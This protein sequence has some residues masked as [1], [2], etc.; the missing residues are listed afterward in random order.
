[1]GFYAP[2]QLVADAK[3]HGVAVR[4]ADVN[5]SDWDCT[6]EPSKCAGRM[7]VRLGLWMVRSLRED[8]AER[9]VE[10][11]KV[12]RPFRSV[13]ELAGRAKL[14]KPA[15]SAL[16]A[17]GA[18]RSMELARRAA[19][20]ESLAAGEP[21]PLYEREQP[22][23]PPRLPEL[24]P[25]EQVAEDY[26]TVGLSLQGHPIGF[27]RPMLDRR[28]VLP[29]ARLGD[30]RDGTFVTVAGVVTHRQRP[31]TSKGIIF[32]SLE[33]ETGGANLVVY[34]NVW[35]KFR[36]A[37]RSSSVM[38]SGA[39]QRDGG[40]TTHLVVGRFVDLSEAVG[41]GTRSRDFH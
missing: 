15:L 20:W 34:P 14:P 26:R 28:G 33:D 19:V 1:M 8:H 23:I 6:P 22:D 37:A 36:R 11:R 40:G 27:V 7:A 39:I 16:A 2:A 5:A 25:S 30:V 41:V 13:P 29:C 9:L 35:A 21:V 17:A 12:G 10:A 18:F 4:P 3:R 38:A 24:S 32:M 31:G